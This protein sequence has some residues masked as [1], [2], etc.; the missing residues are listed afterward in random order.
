MFVPW[1]LRVG[2]DQVEKAIA[3][4]MTWRDVLDALGY[5]YHGNPAAH[6]LL[7]ERWQLEDAEETSC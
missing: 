1:E 2:R 3:E 6:R 7:P 5:R 4:A